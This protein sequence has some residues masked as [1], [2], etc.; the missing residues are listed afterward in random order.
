MNKQIQ[1][2]YKHVDI[3]DA[4]VERILAASKT[5][6]PRRTV[7]RTAV[8]VS[9][10]AAALIV[11]ILSVFLFR[12][13]EPA[14]TSELIM[15][16]YETVLKI[17]NSASGN[18]A[19]IAHDGL[20]VAVESV[21]SNGETVYI[22]L[23]GEYIDDRHDEP[24]PDTL[25]Y[26]YSG[27]DG[28]SFTVNG[29]TAELKTKE[30]V[31]TKSGKLFKGVMEIGIDE[32]S[33]AARL[34]MRIPWFELYS[35]DSLVKKIA[36]PFETEGGVIR[37]YAE[38]EKALLSGDSIL[39]IKSIVQYPRGAIGEYDCGVELQYYVPDELIRDGKDIQARAY[40]EDGSE[41][42]EV[43]A[44]Q[45]NN[46]DGRLMLRSFGFPESRNIRVVLY[47]ANAEEYK[48]IQEYEVT[49]NDLAWPLAFED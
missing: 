31:L 14:N 3:G 34:E 39:Y 11:G 13:A 4:A 2:F 23:F 9:V 26:A 24:A 12:S 32:S 16:S 19:L 49:L 6:K 38:D 7:N 43:N 40:N 33:S 29:R 30:I 44:F 22:A 15:P 37:A 27:G 10:S 21:Y 47:D 18:D 20:A 17:G 28:S 45:Y 1:A 35:G 25:R 41:I 46:R 5:A 48:P 8:I 42:S 36:E